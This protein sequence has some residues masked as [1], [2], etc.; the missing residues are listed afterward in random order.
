MERASIFGYFS[1]V[2]FQW[3]GKKIPAPFAAVFPIFF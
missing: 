1:A 2:N 3:I